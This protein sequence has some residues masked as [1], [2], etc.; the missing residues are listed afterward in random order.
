M[1]TAVLDKVLE[2]I[3]PAYQ[4]GEPGAWVYAVSM[5]VANV[6][7]GWITILILNKLQLTQRRHR[8]EF[9]VRPVAVPPTQP[10]AES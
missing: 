7:M 4:L 3:N 9:E 1:V 6:V 10:A 8:Q 5:L 2:M